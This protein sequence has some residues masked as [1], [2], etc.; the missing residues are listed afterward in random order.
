MAKT[1]RMYPSAFQIADD[2]GWSFESNRLAF[3]DDLKVVESGKTKI[4]KYSKYSDSGWDFYRKVLDNDPGGDNED[5]FDIINK[6]AAL[7]RVAERRKHYQREFQ[8]LTTASWSCIRSSN[9][10]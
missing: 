9:E 10:C 4:S 7:Y 2:A 6:L 8:E 5:L 1:R 3:L